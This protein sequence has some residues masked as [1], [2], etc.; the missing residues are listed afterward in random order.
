MIRLVDLLDLSDVRLRDYK[1]HL[2]TGSN[3]TPLE[4]YRDG[5]FKEWQ[6]EQRNK[7]FECRM[8]LSLIHLRADTWLFAGVY[9]VRGIRRKTKEH[10]YYRTELLPNQ[11]DLI[12][13]IIV[14]TA[15]PVRDSGDCGLPDDR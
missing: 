11:S 10:F 14:R 12:G 8:V 4:A 9:K 15:F 6:E 13:R 2:A 3:P 7:N 5:R 1:I